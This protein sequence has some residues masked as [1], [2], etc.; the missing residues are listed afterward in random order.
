MIY[1]RSDYSQ[2]AHP[3]VMKALV[4][5]NLEH[6]DGY[7]LDTYCETAS[8]MV[9]E[10][11]DKKDCSV[12][13]MVGGTPCNATFIAAALRPYQGVIAPRT[14]HIYFHET[15]AVEA[16]GHRIITVEGIN[17]KLTPDMIDDIWREYEDEHMVMPKMVSISQPTE[18]GSIYSLAEMK[19]I[20]EKCKEYDMYLYVDGARM[21]VALTCEDCDFTL[22]DIAA[23]SDGFYIGGTKNGALMGEALVISNPEIDDHFRWMIKQ[24]RGLLA[25][26]RLIGVQMAALLK[27]GEEGPLFQIAR[28][29]NSMAS[30]LRKGL[31]E[32]G[33]TFYSYSPTNQIFPILPTAVVEKLEEEFFFYRWAPEKNGMIPIRLV[34]GWG[35]QEDEVEALLARVKELLV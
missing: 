28:H 3:E 16:S 25:K 26:G 35:T 9:K 13:M 29:E 23:L 19:A 6:T 4:E 30:R 12:H 24:N 10:L 7:G 31:E 32:A 17:G 15:G 14:S 20:S 27:G 22:K 21:A 11:I 1:F 8:E 5:T 33:C 2:G 34:T 18:I